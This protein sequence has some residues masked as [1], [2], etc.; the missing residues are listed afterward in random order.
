MRFDSIGY[1]CGGGDGPIHKIV[2]VMMVVIVVIVVMV[3][4][5]VMVRQGLSAQ[6]IVMIGT[7]DEL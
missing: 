5:A 7:Y 2:M 6:M 1:P 4:M 3:V